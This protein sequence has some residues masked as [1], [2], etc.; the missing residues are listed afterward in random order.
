MAQV[1][2]IPPPLGFIDTLAAGLV[3]RY[4]DRWDDLARGVI[5]LPTRR[6]C[7]H[8]RDAF[9][10]L[11]GKNALLLPRMQPMG[12]VDEDELIFTPHGVAMPDVPTA[13]SPIRRQ[14]LLAQLIRRK[15]PAMA[16]DQ[17]LQLATA[18]GLFLDQVQIEECSFDRL[19]DLVQQHDLAQHWQQTVMFLEILTRLWPD[20]LRD[21]GCL[22]PAARRRIILD[23]QAEAWRTAPPDYPVIA[24]GSTGS[25]KATA[26]LLAVIAGLPQGHVIVPGL[27]RDAPEEVWQDIDETHPQ[28][29]MKELI[30]RCGVS[31]HDVGL[32]H[33]DA[34]PQS[35]ARLRW[36]GE[37]MRPASV[38][39]GWRALTGNDIPPGVLQGVTQLDLDHT[40]HEA[41]TIALC[42]RHALET[43]DRTAMLVTPDRALAERVRLLLTRWHIT[44]NDSGG[45]A[46]ADTP[47][48]AFLGMVLQAAKPDAGVIDRLG[49]LKQ[50]LAVAGM[51]LADCRNL[52]RQ[53]EILL[54]KP[55]PDSVPMPEAWVSV[56]ALWM[57]LTLIWAEKHNLTDWIA[58]H[59]QVAE[60]MAASPDTTGAD[61]L[62]DGEAGNAA[63]EWFL[64][65]AGAAAG[66]P[67]VSGDEYAALYHSLAGQV[68]VRVAGGQHP[69]LD[70]L[71]PLEARLIRA[72]LV[73]MG[74]LN[75]GSWPPQAMMDPWMSR[76][77][78]SDFG[79]SLPE[80][81]IG[82]AAHD[83][84]Q[85]ASARDVVLTRARRAGNAPTVPSRFLLQLDTVLK[86]V[87]LTLSD[88]AASSLPWGEWAAVLDEPVM[89]TIRACD[90]P[91]PCPP[92]AVRP[93]GLS[94]TDIGLWRRNPYAIYAKHI[95][96]LR[97]LDDLDLPLDGSDRGTIIHDILEHAVKAMGSVWPDDAYNRLVDLGREA[98][99]VY[100]NHPEV[101]AFW[102]PQFLRLARWFVA[103]QKERDQQ[104]ITIVAAEVTGR[105]MVNGFTL[106]GRADRIDAHSDAGLEIIDYKTGVVPSK[107]SIKTGYDPQL[108]LLGWMVEQGAFP[109][110]TKSTVVAL[111]H[112]SIK[113]R[114][115]DAIKTVD[116]VSDLIQSAADGLR[117]MIDSFDHDDIPY[118]A[119]PKPAWAP[120]YDDY[121]HL[122]RLAE[123]GVGKD[124]DTP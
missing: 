90:P 26:R 19:P 70:I 45:A 83:F 1:Y 114:G 66:F 77:M 78:K 116:P 103:Q 72:D 5:L 34:A 53:V 15:D 2:T 25:V 81:R 61:R 106:N 95:L 9:L 118:V 10:R 112:W 17:A 40:Q 8:L 49:L 31:R 47:T 20:V 57:P 21:E 119:V 123:W 51:A 13:I 54:R 60:A 30:Q 121:A 84:V 69:R 11:G 101:R 92:R 80:R 86:T 43:P 115:S 71:G 110:I 117:H 32:W 7:R 39:D 104:G 64:E 18:L 111:A 87:G 96:K 29:N 38:S 22:D 67:A 91:K 27:D 37:A 33:G 107:E 6:A 120:K 73:I 50:P 82:L 109:D 89:G 97:A 108:P 41:Q 56:Q 62:W 93:Q 113:G 59:R 63:A 28:Y 124:E 102:W 16:L 85:L 76:P 75:E 88:T 65:W 58:A 100:D 24:A 74:G 48:G 52:V 68:R 12:D 55:R 46:L 94:V 44:V 23:H 4:R 35:R 79:L 3:D 105:L 99:A 36:L 98:F 14:L 122:A 42:L